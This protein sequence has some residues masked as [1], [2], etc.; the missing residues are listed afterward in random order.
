MDMPYFIVLVDDH[1]IIRRWIKK[2]IEESP[3]LKVVGEV[4]DGL[5]LIDYLK[6]NTPRPDMVIMDISMPKMGG[7]EA[8]EKIKERCPRIKV[9]I[10]TIHN[11]KEYMDLALAKGADGYLLKNEADPELFTA[12]STIRQGGTYICPHMR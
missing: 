10:L 11:G 5:E 8:T 1:D 4:G 6:T 9:L 3:K 2:I 7:I 12:I